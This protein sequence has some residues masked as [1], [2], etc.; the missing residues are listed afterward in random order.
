MSDSGLSGEALWKAMANDLFRGTRMNPQSGLEL[1]DDADHR[2]ALHILL[3]REEGAYTVVRSGRTLDLYLSVHFNTVATIE[4]RM[5]L[6][7]ADKIITSE[8]RKVLLGS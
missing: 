3:E 6:A 4:T 7:S 2:R 1:P 8:N 5:A